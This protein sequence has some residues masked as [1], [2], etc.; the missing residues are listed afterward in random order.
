MR[1]AAVGIVIDTMLAQVLLRDNLV[2][3]LNFGQYRLGPLSLN[4]CPVTNRNGLVGC[5][6]W[7]QLPMT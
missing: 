5:A 6:I 7:R 2:L 4:Y 3:I 1:K